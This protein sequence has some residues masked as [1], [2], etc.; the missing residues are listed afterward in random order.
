[1]TIAIITHS[2]CLKHEMGIGHPERPQRIRAIEDQLITSGIGDFMHYYDAPLATPEQLELAHSRKHIDY[3]FG[4]SPPDDSMMA[5]IDPDTFMNEFTLQAALRSAGSAIAAVDKVLGDKTEKRVFCNV[6]PA[7]HHAERDAAM[8]FCFFNN[9]AIA[10]RHAVRDYGLERVAIVDF[11]VHHG[12]GTEDIVGDDP[13]I[14]FCSTY[15]HPL[16]PERAL[17]SKPGFLINAPLP[18]GAG[19]AEFRE[20]ITEFWLPELNAFKPQLMIISAGFDAHIED[21]MAGLRL[22]E[23]DYAWV[24]KE[25]CKIADE[26]GEGRIVSLLEGGYDTSALARSVVAHLRVLMNL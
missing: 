8:G 12:N 4:K 17:P 15:Q 5:H 23:A 22:V 6:R 13:Q 21:E 14:L 24:T 10:A 25:L 16:Y 1:M 3:I 18:E 19:G 9:A 7:G 20:T 2:D 11:D 26:Y